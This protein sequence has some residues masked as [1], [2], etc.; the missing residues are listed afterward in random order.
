MQYPPCPSDVLYHR[1]A[2]YSVPDGWPALA[3][4]PQLQEAKYGKESA[5]EDAGLPL[6]TMAY[7]AHDR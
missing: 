6:L 3:A 4:A 7:E 5:D 2:P 1:A